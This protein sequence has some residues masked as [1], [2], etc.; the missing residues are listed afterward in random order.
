MHSPE[1]NA[2]SPRNPPRR[3]ARNNEPP[4]RTPPPPEPDKSVPPP[5]VDL[6]EPKEVKG[7]RT[8]P[9][10]PKP[11][12]TRTVKGPAFFSQRPAPRL[13]RKERATY[14]I[15]FRRG[16]FG[17]LVIQMELVVH[18]HESGKEDQGPVK[19]AMEWRDASKHELE[20]IA[21]GYFQPE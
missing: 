11:P 8:Y 21:R 14:H 19:S 20:E 18:W 17:R 16:W 1:K 2:E 5:K 6:G 13:I 9:N 12:P 7:Y 3:R 15:R 10:A 4:F